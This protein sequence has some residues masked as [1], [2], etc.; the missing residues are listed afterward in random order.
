MEYHYCGTCR[1]GWH[2][3][4]DLGSDRDESKP[5]VGECRRHAPQPS[6]SSPASGHHAT[7]W[8]EVHWDDG[9]GDWITRNV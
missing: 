6:T 8:P 9:C 4:E 1:W 2:F 7:L 3:A 5:M